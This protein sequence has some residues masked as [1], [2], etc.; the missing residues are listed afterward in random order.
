MKPFNSESVRLWLCNACGSPDPE[1]R[2]WVNANTDETTGSYDDDGD[3]FCG[4]CETESTLDA[5]EVSG[6]S[7]AEAMAH[8]RHWSVAFHRAL[9]AKLTEYSTSKMSEAPTDE[10]RQPLPPV[11]QGPHETS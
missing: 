2:I 4:A 6:D 3:C 1:V 11:I 7:L 10:P 5:F 9:N 8:A